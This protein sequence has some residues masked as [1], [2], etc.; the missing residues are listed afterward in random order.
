MT[1]QHISNVVLLTNYFPFD[2]GEE[3]LEAELPIIASTFASVTVIPLM[4]TAASAQTRGLPDNVRLIEVNGGRGM[5]LRIMDLARQVVSGRK[6]WDGFR[7]AQGGRRV[8]EKAFDAYFESRA[9]AVLDRL[10]ELEPT[11]RPAPGVPTVIY[12]YW[13]YLTARVGAGLKNRWSTTNPL[14]FVSRGHGYDVNI[15]ASPINYLP[16]REYLL[17]QVDELYPV[18]EA[19]TRWFREKYPRFS[20]KVHTR[21]L[22]SPAVKDISRAKQDP[23]HIVSCST[24][25]SL[26]RL[27]VIADAVEQLLPDAPDM[28]WTH[29][30]SGAT[31]YATKLAKDIRARLGTAVRF[32]GQMSNSEVHRW[33]QE[34]E[35]TAFVNVSTSEGVPVSIMEAMSYSLP[36]VATDVGGTSELFSRLMF[37]GLLPKDLS[38]DDLGQ[39]LAKLH[40][41]SSDK[42]SAYAAASREEWE[43]AWNSKRNF[44]DFMPD[45]A[46]LD[47]D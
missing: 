29:I 43:K 13:F 24:I 10:I 14:R 38:G 31:E 21:R 7:A 6:G 28:V 41:A 46:H 11:F 36:I 42:Y 26:K 37:D 5:S 17:D 15:G 1:N 40:S 22:G 4:T 2:K 8:I 34:N 12:S 33:Y 35:A 30:G 3:Y 47:E 45:L 25:R 39:T 44:E 23:L 20:Q 19:T 27:E 9:V 32:E 18:S 16:E